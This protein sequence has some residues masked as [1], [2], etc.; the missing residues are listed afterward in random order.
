MEVVPGACVSANGGQERKRCFLSFLE[1]GR[2]GDCFVLVKLVSYVYHLLYVFC[3]PHPPT[4]NPLISLLALRFFVFNLLRSGFVSVFF[5]AKVGI[6]ARRLTRAGGSTQIDASLCS[7]DVRCRCDVNAMF[8]QAC[9]FLF[10]TWQWQGLAGYGRSIRRACVSDG[11]C[12]RL[13]KVLRGVRCVHAACVGVG[14]RFALV[15]VRCWC[16]CW[17]AGAG[18]GILKSSF[19]V[20]ICT[21]A[22]LAD[23]PPMQPPSPSPAALSPIFFSVMYGNNVICAQLLEVLYSE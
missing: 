4:G 23:R 12:P 16:W 18:A 14:A 10:R 8:C 11:G 13:S 22:N 5:Y 7:P 9:T 19:S 20:A 6:A 17:Y 21:R 2:S 15:I 1:T 3:A